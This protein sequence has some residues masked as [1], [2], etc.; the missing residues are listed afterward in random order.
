M[1]I[2][3]L[4]NLS[5]P[6]HPQRQRDAPLLCSQRSCRDLRLQGSRQKPLSNIPLEL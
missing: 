4:R 3:H 6:H 1:Q 2:P 5:Q